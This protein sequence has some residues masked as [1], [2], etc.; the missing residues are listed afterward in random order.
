MSK[1]EN[2]LP[3]VMNIKNLLFE[4]LKKVNDI[5]IHTPKENSAPHI[6]NFSIKGFKA[7]VVVHSLEESNIYVSTTSACSSK[8][9]SVSHTLLGMGVEGD[10]AKSAIRVSLSFENT[11]EEAKMVI[12][13]IKQTI[14][15]LGRT[16]IKNE[17]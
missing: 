14:Q 9:K 11:E 10:I 16:M 3:K 13:S 12:K 4:E 7:E 1:M 8:I 15:K 2:N 17:I 6:L 5:I